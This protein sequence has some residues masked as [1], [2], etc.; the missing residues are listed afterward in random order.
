VVTGGA[1]QER[2]GRVVIVIICLCGAGCLG[3]LTA[4]LVFY[5]K[6][7]PEAELEKHWRKLIGLVIVLAVGVPI[8][9]LL[10]M[11]DTRAADGVY[12]NGFVGQY[13]SLWSLLSYGAGFFYAWLAIRVVD[14][15]RQRS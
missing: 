4:A 8:M 12:V 5:R 1:S 11:N 10:S 15:T 9:A 3:A 7:V 13:L 14:R 6:L 2:E